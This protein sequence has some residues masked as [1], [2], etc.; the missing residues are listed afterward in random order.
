VFNFV[1]ER[2][3][4]KL[5]DWKGH[6][7]S[8]A[9]REVLMK[10]MVQV[11]PTYVMSCFKLQD[12]LCDHMENMISKFWRGSKQE[13]RKIPWIAWNV[14]CK[15]KCDGGMGFRTLKDFNFAMLAK[16]GCHILQNEQ[17]LLAS[18][19]KSRYFPRIKRK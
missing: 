11:I 6:F 1:Q 4:K 14:I 17:S 12:S 13:E 18:C 8:Y 10:A 7:L 9:A 5:K 2:I 15:E 16:Q 19:L 3:W